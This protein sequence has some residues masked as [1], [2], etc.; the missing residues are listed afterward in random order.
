MVMVTL[1][2][3]VVAVLSSSEPH[4][5][6]SEPMPVAAARPKPCRR[7][8]RRV[9]PALADLE[10]MSGL[11][12][13]RLSGAVAGGWGWSGAASKP[14]RKSGQAGQRLAGQHDRSAQ[15]AGG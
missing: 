2:S 5:L 6:R 13:R 9:G 10:V 8:A 14:V 7:N 3:L 1:P 12:L 15:V 4:A 11:L